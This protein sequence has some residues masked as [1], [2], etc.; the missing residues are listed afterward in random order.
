MARTSSTQL[1]YS[2]QRHLRIRNHHLPI[3][4]HQPWYDV[5]S[6]YGRCF[7]ESILIPHLRLLHCLQRLQLA[8]HRLDPVLLHHYR[9]LLDLAPLVRQA[10]ATT[11]MV[12]GPMG[13]TAECLLTLLDDTDAVLLCLAS[14]LPGHPGKHVSRPCSNSR[15]RSVR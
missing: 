5:I 14:V 2:S 6:S 3:I 11:P 1:E 10:T 15:L 12:I 7:K 9:R 4:A 8:R 13:P